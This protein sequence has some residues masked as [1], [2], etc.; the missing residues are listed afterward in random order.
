LP[1]QYTERIQQLNL[2]NLH[3]GR[4][5]ALEINKIKREE[6]L[7]QIDSVNLPI[8]SQVNDPDIAKIA[9]AMLYLGEGLH[10]HKSRSFYFGNSNPIVISLFL[11][12]LKSIAPFQLEK[13][14]CTV[15]CRA[16]QDTDEL[17]NYWS[18]ITEIPKRLFY[19]SRIDPRTIGKPTVNSDYKGV[20]RIDYFDTK[21]RHDLES[22]GVLI[23]NQLAKLGR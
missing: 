23:Y 20:L 4:R 8:A 2:T 12:F 14:R 19:K 16:D 5:I 17:V 18:T 7:Q 9:L 21:V 10:S 11:N 15:Q 6:Y 1:P 13:V 3:K 22:L